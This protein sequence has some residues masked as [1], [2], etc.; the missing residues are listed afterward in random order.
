MNQHLHWYLH[1]LERGLLR[2]IFVLGNAKFGL[3]DHIYLFIDH[4][5]KMPK[6]HLYFVVFIQPQYL[7]ALCLP[8]D[9]FPSYFFPSFFANFK[10]FFFFANL[11]L[12]W[13]VCWLN[14]AIFWPEESDFE[15]VLTRNW[16][17]VARQKK[18]DHISQKA[19][20]K[21][22]AKTNLRCINCLNLCI[23]SY[24][25]WF[26]SLFFYVQI[27]S[28]CINCWCLLYSFL[29]DDYKVVFF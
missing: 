4:V 14:L 11:I 17:K 5:Q 3:K 22:V 15:D 24:G 21:Q 23:F 28:K 10:P 16:S 25:L 6:N 1:L 20:F 9:S 12:Q 29:M 8:C 7:L 26:N 2:A 18:T 27:F 19:G 13:F